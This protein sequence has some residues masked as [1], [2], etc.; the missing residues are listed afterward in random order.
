MVMIALRQAK[1]TAV[2][3]RICTCCILYTA[4]NTLPTHASQLGGPWTT[5]PHEAKKTVLGNAVTYHFVF[6]SVVS[7]STDYHQILKKWNDRWPK[8]PWPKERKGWTGCFEIMPCHREPACF[9]RKAA[10]QVTK[11]AC[12]GDRKGFRWYDV[13]TGKTIKIKYEFK[14]QGSCNIIYCKQHAY[15]KETVFLI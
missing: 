5:N 6:E 4:Y 14:K 2:S 3:F 7:L 13:G 11:A 9:V 15:D 12:L 8:N 10:G 1:H